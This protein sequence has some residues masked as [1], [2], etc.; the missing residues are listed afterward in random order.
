M[1][2]LLI[3]LIYIVLIFVII[4]FQY[5]ILSHFI[6]NFNFIHHIHKYLLNKINIRLLNKFEMVY[7]FFLF[8]NIL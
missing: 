5:S 8:E 4:L 1:D 6:F 3:A 2:T 7:I